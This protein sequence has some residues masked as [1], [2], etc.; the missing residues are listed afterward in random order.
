MAAAMER[1]ANRRYHVGFHSLLVDWGAGVDVLV[2][3]AVVA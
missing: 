1:L 2:M 3:R